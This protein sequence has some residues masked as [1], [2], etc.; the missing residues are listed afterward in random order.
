MTGQWVLGVFFL[1][2]ISQT[3][4]W[5]SWHPGNTNAF[6]P[7]K[8]HRERLLPL[9]KGNFAK[10][11]N[12]DINHQVAQEEKAAPYHLINQGCLGRLDFHPYLGVAQRRQSRDLGLLSLWAVMRPSPHTLTTALP[13]GVI[14]A[15]AWGSLSCHPHPDSNKQP[16]PFPECQRRPGGTLG[17]A[18][19]SG[20]N[21]WCQRKTCWNRRFK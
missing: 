7:K 10:K 14:S 9:G 17:L 4:C 2:H 1:P 18:P 15:E 19:P 3:G 21:R 12:S 8:P 5:R 13:A 20:S 11:E 6:R 16:L